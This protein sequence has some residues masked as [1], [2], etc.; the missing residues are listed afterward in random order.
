VDPG[1]HRP[2]LLHYVMLRHRTKL[3]F[4]EAGQ[5]SQDVTGSGLDAWGSIPRRDR[6]FTWLLRPDR[7]WDLLSFYTSGTWDYLPKGRAVKTRS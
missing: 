6:N 5:F 1:L 4:R 2:I 3:A 7:L